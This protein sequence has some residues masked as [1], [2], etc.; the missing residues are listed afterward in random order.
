MRGTGFELNRFGWV[1]ATAD[2]GSHSRHPVLG[3][4]NVRGLGRDGVVLPAVV[5]GVRAVGS[6]HGTGDLR[7]PLRGL[8]SRATP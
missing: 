1:P 3:S 7:P 6:L 8:R 2:P 4:R 5:R